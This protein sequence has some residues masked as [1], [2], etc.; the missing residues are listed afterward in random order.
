M[1]EWVRMP[2]YWVKDQESLL[3]RN[4]KWSGPSKSDQIAALMLFVVLNHH[5]NDITTTSFKELGLCALTYSQ[6]SEISGLSRAKVAGG[7]RILKDHKLISQVGNG[8]NNIYKIANFGTQGGWSKLPAKK[9]YSSD[10][11]KINSFYK[12]NLRSKNELNALKTYFLIIALRNNEINYAQIS[13]DKISQYTG[14][15]RS[16]IR[17]AI[18]L[19]INLGLV[20]VD[21]GSSMVNQEL[22][23]N[24]YR[25]CYLEPYKHRGTALREIDFT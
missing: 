22:T 24:M 14:I 9:L 1:K 13:Y 12:F 5:A 2:S 3:L 23:T 15:N 19:L 8:R 17:S 20:H 21:V 11:K 6:L 4:F 7:L 25:P 18:S 16:E 10:L